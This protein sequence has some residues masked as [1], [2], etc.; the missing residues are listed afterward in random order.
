MF[1]YPGTGFPSRIGEG[2][3]KGFNINVHLDCGSTDKDIIKAF[4]DR[5]IPAVEKFKPDL[6]LISAGFD[7]RQDDLLGCFDISDQGFVTLTRMVKGLA[8]EYCQGKIVS[9]LE[10]GY[11]LQ[12]NASAAASHILALMD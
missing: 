3:G 8:D 5:L 12:G 10:G 7:S 11:N 9:M 1:A 4:K 6:I 2:E